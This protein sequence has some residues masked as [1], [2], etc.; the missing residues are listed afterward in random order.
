[1]SAFEIGHLDTVVNMANKGWSPAP[2]AV[3]LRA[4]R[5]RLHPA[6]VGNLDYL[7]KQIP[8]GS[9]WTVTGVGRGAWPMVAAGIVMGGNVRV[10]FEDNI[11]LEKGHKAASNGELVERSYAWP[12]S[13]A[14]RSPPP[15][16][17]ERSCPW[18]NF[19]LFQSPQ[20][21]IVTPNSP[22]KPRTKQEELSMQKKGNK[23]GTHRVIEPQGLLTQAAKKIDNTMECWSNEILCDVSALNIDSASFTPDL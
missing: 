21:Y 9:T 4:G 23:Y 3:Q 2:H 6:T 7:V 8:A 22:T 15:T 10:G 11:Y 12:R 13:W 18:H 19:L 1:M 17:P 14:V 20:P 16:R 5:L